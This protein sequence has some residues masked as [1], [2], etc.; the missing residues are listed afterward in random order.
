[1]SN[2]I[3]TVQKLPLRLFVQGLFRDWTLLIHQVG[4]PFPAWG[5]Q[6][7]FYARAIALLS[8]AAGGCLSPICWSSHPIFLSNWSRGAMHKQKNSSYPCQDI[9]YHKTTLLEI[10]SLNGRVGSSLLCVRV[11]NMLLNSAKVQCNKIYY[12]NFIVQNAASAHYAKHAEQL[13]NLRN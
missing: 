6:S 3:Q 1:M 8:R 12:K 7:Q 9:G 10:R 4:Q 13:R 11:S 2:V 5:K